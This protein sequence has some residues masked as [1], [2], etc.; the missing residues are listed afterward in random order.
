MPGVAE[1]AD[2]RALNSL[3]KVCV[4]KDDEWRV[5]AELHRRAFDGFGTLLHQHFANLRRSGER[6]LANNGV[7]RHFSTDF[8]RNPSDDIDY[9][10]RHAS[11]LSQFGESKC[12]Q[13][14]F[15][16]RFAYDRTP[17]SQRRRNLAC[18][19]GVR[20][21]P[22]RNAGDDTHGLFYYDNAFVIGWRRNS[23]AIDSL[24]F[25]GKP[26][27][28]AGAIGDFA[29]SL[30]QRLTLLGRQDLRQILLCLHHQVKPL[31]ENGRTFLGRFLPP[32]DLCFFGCLDCAPRFSGSAFRYLSNGLA[33]GRIQYS[34]SVATVCFDP[35]TI[36]IS[37]RL[38]EALIRN[39]HSHVT[40][41]HDHWGSQV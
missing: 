28:I 40:P 29:P 3:V 12:R 10:C 22:R 9:A 25:F 20:E 21:I 38:Q 1:L 14:G 17:R 5:A 26:L 19:H 15:V 8:S 24:A 36:N 37:L 16:S 27:D 35:L 41:G 39:L 34:E 33:I 23:V 31:T 2:N 6:Q 30:C 32:A 4:V 7:A 11:S 18:Q 13:R